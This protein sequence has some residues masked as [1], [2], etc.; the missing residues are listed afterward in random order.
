MN[1]DPRQARLSML[2]IGEVARR[3][4]LTVKAVR[5][6]ADTG[7]VA[8]T[9]RT[10]AGYRLY[11]VE[12]LARLDLIRTLRELGVD[13]SA[14]R[15]VT[16]RETSLPEVA[17]AHAEALTAQIRELRLR[18]AVLRAVAKLCDT[19]EELELVHQL[20]RLSADERR[21]LTADFFD[22]VFGGLRPEP[23]VLRSM[24]P[25]LPDDPDAE[26]VQAWVELATLLGDP[27]FRASV[28]RMAQRYAAERAPGLRPDAVALVR[29]LAG[30]AVAARLDPASPEC[31]SLVAEVLT[32]YADTVG[33]PDGPELRRQLAATLRSADDP[34]WQRYL[35]LLSVINGWP[36]PDS[37]TPVLDW[38]LAALAARP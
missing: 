31:D 5:F 12:A 11:S 3:T 10:E 27:D 13:L 14:A 7:I 26:Q 15:A 21:R 17:A 18:R 19:P 20:A 32:R 28:R 29:D 8:P 25:Q 33:R 34:R 23:G 22:D 4:G 2:S 24:T 9:E 16:D 37:L 30:F 6:Y 1:G 38:F 36:V 35:A